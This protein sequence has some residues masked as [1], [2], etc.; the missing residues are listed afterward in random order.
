MKIQ[1]LLLSFAV[2]GISA[3]TT[4]LYENTD[5]HFMEQC[6]VKEGT[7]DGALQRMQ[8]EC[9]KKGKTIDSQ[10]KGN[11]AIVLCRPD[12]PK[13]VKPEGT[14]KVDAKKADVIPSAK[15]AVNQQAE[16]K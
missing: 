10:V 6:S 13:D 11:K 15:Q 5:I 12:V 16:G 8:A 2:S 3:C 4:I 14:P 9:A 7:C 1:L